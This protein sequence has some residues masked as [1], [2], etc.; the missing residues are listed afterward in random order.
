M[1]DE[2]TVFSSKELKDS[3]QNMRDLLSQK[4]LTFLLGAGCS[5]CA[6]LPL[7]SSLTDIVI[8]HKAISVQ[9]KKLLDAICKNFDGATNANIENY[10]SEIVDFHAIVE[11][12]DSIGANEPEIALGSEKYIAHDFQTALNEIK[13]AIVS[14]VNEQEVNVSVH[15]RFVKAIHGSLQAGK[16]TRCVDYYVLNYDTLIE[17]ALGLEQIPYCDG[18]A[19]STTGWWDPVVFNVEETA[20]RVFKVHGSIDWCLLSDDT[21]PRRVRSGITT[22]SERK[23]ILI[24]PSASKYQETQRDPFAQI[25]QHM[26]ASLAPDIN[27]EMILIICGYSF[28]DSHINHEIENALYKS[29]GRLTLLVFNSTDYPGDTLEA[30]LG[31][32]KITEQIQVYCN[33]SYIHGKEVTTFKD[34]LPWWKFEVITKLLGGEQ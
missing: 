25:L 5:A 4:N 24:Y 10:M 13:T 11:R 33:K 9:S 29:S 30:W 21:L 26:R 27:Q 28:G 17:D 16:A 3:V 1:S 23:H 7:M 31:D 32:P 19:G 14:A 22:A 6:G 15:Q 2:L 20:A 34:D 12:R 18:F 8:N